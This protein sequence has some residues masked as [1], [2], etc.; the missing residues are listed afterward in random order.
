MMR[1]IIA[2]ASAMIALTAGA[3]AATPSVSVKG[4]VVTLTVPEG[5]TRE[6]V[7]FSHAKP[8]P[9]PQGSTYSP[10]RAAEDFAHAILSP[11]RNSAVPGYSPGGVGNG[12]QAPVILVAPTKEDAAGIPHGDVTPEEFGAY[13][14][15]YSTARADLS[16]ATNTFYPYRAAG[17]LFFLISGASYVCSASL[18]RPGLVVTAAHCV[19]N[20]GKSTF[21]SG[22]QFVPGY[23]NGVAPY[24]TWTA[25]S[26]NVLTAYYNGTD[27]CA[28]SGVIC[29]DDVALLALNAQDGAVP[30]TKVGW[31]GYG[32]NG[33]GFTSSGITHVTQLGY[34]VCLDNG[35]YMERNDSQGTKTSS[36]SN[37]TIIGSLMCGGS[38]GG[39]WLVNFGSPP[40]LESGT[41]H[42]T[43]PNNNS[44]VGVTSWGFTD[45]TQKAMG[46]APFTSGNIQLLR[47]N[48]CAS[49]PSDC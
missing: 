47:T 43:D 17:K 28:Q 6:H 42:G 38:S 8:L 34:P 21:Y 29:Q 18:I 37:N 36:Y 48:V 49:Y 30:G 20:F 35:L 23:R 16:S 2:G 45:T 33:Y 13:N 12:R 25:A 5:S 4:D 14:I 24:G 31:Y 44:V 41:S 1:I 26:A 7:D 15:P 27:S 39:P 32:Y 22:W 19:A 9:L 11:V 10:A 3:L 40:T 46:A